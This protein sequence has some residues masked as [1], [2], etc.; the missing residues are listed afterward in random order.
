MPNVILEAMWSGVPVVAT[1]VGGVSEM[2]R[3][4]I[5]GLLCPPQNPEALAGTIKRLAADPAFA[6][7]LAANAYRRLVEEFTFEKH[8]N[9]TLDLYR[10]V[11]KED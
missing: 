2:L 1:A 5:E 11:T 3:D 8:M 4:G 6:E 7:T 9:A 10:R